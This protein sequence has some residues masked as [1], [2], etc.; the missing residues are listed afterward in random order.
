MNATNK[1]RT[2]VIV[3]GKGESEQT[4][5]ASALSSIQKK[6]M[7]ESSD[8]ILRIEPVDVSILKAEKETKKEKFMFFFFPREKTTYSIEL[9]V[10]VEIT[11]ILLKNV[12]FTEK[13]LRG[14]TSLYN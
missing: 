5:F 9:R 12:E 11:T 8:V 1:N 14:L 3:S 10:E 2:E 7:S 6:I 4:A 13:H